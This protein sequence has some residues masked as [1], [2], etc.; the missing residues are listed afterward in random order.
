MLSD[1]E[2]I[3][4]YQDVEFPGSFSGARNFQ[5]FLKTDKNVDVPLSKIYSLLKQI[6]LYIMNQ[7]RIRTFPRRNYV[8]TSFGQVAQADLAEMTMFNKFKYFLLLVDLFSRHLYVEPLRRKTAPVVRKGF[9]KIFE[10]FKSPIV[11]LETDQVRN[12]IHTFR[13]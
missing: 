13:L 8:V 11:K 10:E 4:L 7:K 9:E 5:M 3:Q 6:P 12:F 2:L 1:N